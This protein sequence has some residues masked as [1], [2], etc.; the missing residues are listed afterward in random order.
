MTIYNEKNDNLYKSSMYNN[1]LKKGDILLFKAYKSPT[2]SQNLIR[3]G[4][5]FNQAATL[6]Q[7]DTV[8][9]CRHM[10]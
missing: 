5:L 4:E 9:T 10:H 1:D 6:G 7:N 8:S 3:F 2:I